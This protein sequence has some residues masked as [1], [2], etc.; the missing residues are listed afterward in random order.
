MGLQWIPLSLQTENKKPLGRSLGFRGSVWRQVVTRQGLCWCV[1]MPVHR[2][3][4]STS[5]G[6]TEF[7]ALLLLPDWKKCYIHSWVPARSP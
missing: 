6:S 3:P 5:H 7:P 2:C 1:S 4:L